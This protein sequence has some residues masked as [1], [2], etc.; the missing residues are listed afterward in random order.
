MC[1]RS[2]ASTSGPCGPAS[3]SKLTPVGP[4]LPATK[5]APPEVSSASCTPAR[6]ISAAL[7]T[8]PCVAS[9]NAFAPNVLVVSTR[10]PACMYS[11]WICRT[12]SGWLRFT[13][14]KQLVKKTPRS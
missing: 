10:A 9:R 8:S 14:S 6:L 12:S 13:A 5:A 1:A 3:A 4:T 2:A 7:S 11:W